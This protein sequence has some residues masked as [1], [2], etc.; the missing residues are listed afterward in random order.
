MKTSTIM[1]IAA[2]LV[3]FASLTAFNI[4]V[5]KIYQSGAY[6]SRFRGMDFTDLKGVDN[7]NIQSA[8]RMT[9]RIEQG[10]KEGIYIT[11]DAKNNVI[12]SIKANTLT[13]D[14]SAESKS[15]GYRSW[16]DI[17]ITT[18]NIAT[19]NLGSSNVND[20]GKGYKEGD[21]SLKG[22]KLNNLDLTIGKFVNVSLE[23]IS[24]NTLKAQVGNEKDGRAKLSISS[25]TE[26]NSAQFDVPGAS[27]LELYNPKLVKAVYNLTDSATVTLSGKVVNII[28]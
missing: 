17:I 5:K 4:D 15:T 18:K 22:F 13:L 27:T 8:D 16:S 19:L 24:I 6:K 3:T 10:D 25:D 21:V 23:G 14:L 12:P 1:I 28:K 2:V 11:G 20:P 26:I 7:I 9:I